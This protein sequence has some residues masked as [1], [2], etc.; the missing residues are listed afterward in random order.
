[1]FLLQI[2]RS[3]LCQKRKDVRDYLFSEI[4]TRII[5]YKN[6]ES[7]LEEL[8]EY[9]NEVDSEFVKKCIRAVGKIAIRY[10]KSVEKCMGILAKAI[11]EVRDAA[12]HAEIIV[13]ELL[14]V[15]FLLLRQCKIFWE[16]IR[17]SITLMGCS[18]TWWAYLT[19]LQI[20]NPRKLRFGYLPNMLRRSTMFQWQLSRSGFP[21]LRCKSVE[22][23]LKSS[24]QR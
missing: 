9:I 23:S 12:D 2:F 1:M 8:R 14:I 11:K 5:N 6:Y 17:L 4:L 3:L 21:T 10:E 15:I 22:F 24:A 20:A 7:V 16:S 18:L 19:M 13:N